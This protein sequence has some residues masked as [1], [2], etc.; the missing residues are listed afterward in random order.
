MDA[1][2]AVATIVRAALGDALA[3]LLPIACAGCGEPDVDLCDGC[4]A[5]LAVDLR[6]REL[7][8]GDVWTALAFE[9]V[10]ARVVRA[11]K[12]DGRTGLLRHLAPAFAV[13][14]R[15]AARA[16]GLDDAGAAGVVFVPVPTSRRSYRSRGFRVPDLLLARAGLPR[17]RLL[18]TARLTADQRGLG[19]DDR[20]RNVE[21]SMVARGAAS[22]RVIVVDDVVTTGATLDE[23]IRALR[24]GGAE[25]LGA[26]A[27]AATPR[28]SST[29]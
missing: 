25:V 3:L 10:T 2:P 20:R 7:R 22:R 24:A 17:A 23:A 6:R 9:G 18:K 1:S 14:A 11:V 26:V 12:A 28:H 19:V 13:A 15:T 27:L 29:R 4:R 21:G 5:A 8:D 16:R